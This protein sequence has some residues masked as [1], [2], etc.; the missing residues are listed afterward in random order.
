MIATQQM[1][2]DLAHAINHLIHGRKLRLEGSIQQATNNERWGESILS[3]LF[4]PVQVDELM[5]AWENSFATNPL[6]LP[7]WKSILN[8]E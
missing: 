2:R 1:H 7:E 6:E 3:Q 4:S 8:P 5:T